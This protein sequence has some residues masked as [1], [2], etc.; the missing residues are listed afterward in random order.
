MTKPTKRFRGNLSLTCRA[1][2][3]VRE[4]GLRVFDAVISS[5]DP[6][7]MP[8]GTEIL[9]HGPDSVDLSAVT[10]GRCMVLDGHRG[11]PAGKVDKASIAGGQIVA[12]LLVMAGGR[13]GEIGDMWEKNISTNLSVGYT[14]LETRRDHVTENIYVTKWVLNEVSIVGVP[15]DKAA[16]ITR[17]DGSPAD[18]PDFDLINYR[19][20]RDADADAKPDAKPDTKSERD[21][22]DAKPDTKPEISPAQKL[23]PTPKKH[24]GRKMITEEEKTKLDVVKADIVSIVNNARESF[25]FDDENGRVVGEFREKII[26]DLA[27]GSKT[28]DAC[29]GETQAKM[30]EIAAKQTRTGI[31]TVD[32][33]PD[34]KKQTAA[35]R[36]SLGKVDWFEMQKKA[37]LDE[38][39]GMDHFIRAA[40]VQARPSFGGT[41]KI[42]GLINEFQEENKRQAGGSEDYTA[43]GFAIP[44]E[45]VALHHYNNAARAAAINGERI[46]SIS[47]SAGGKGGVT[48]QT[49]VQL[50][51]LVEFLYPSAKLNEYGCMMLTGLTNNIVIPRQ[52]AKATAAYYAENATISMS[53]Y[54]IGSL[55]FS[56]KRIGAQSGYSLQSL[57]NVGGNFM[58]S[59]TMSTLM[60]TLYSTRDDVFLNGDGANGKPKGI[61]NTSGI[62]MVSHGTNG[63]PPTLALT[64]RANLEIRKADVPG[65]PRKL[66]TPDIFEKRHV[67]QK[68]VGQ[69]DSRMIYDQGDP[70]IMDNPVWTNSLPGNLSKGTG[71]N[72]HA[73]ITSIPSE[74][75]CCE[76]G[77]IF[78]SIDAD[79]AG[80]AADGQ[81]VVTIQ[82]FN[83]I[84]VRRLDAFVVSKDIVVI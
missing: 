19:A 56:P 49:D 36:G 53:D 21:A 48:V 39:V 75:I 32:V 84:G 9:E 12:E 64:R 68:V 78:V 79:S 23:D 59:L 27:T 82:G 31:K 54:T 57:V 65:M 16:R 61:L 28:P 37:N 15:A 83:D 24:E 34:D 74:I 66:M 30:L 45:L 44:Q 42:T 13:S 29:R 41:D 4:D 33:K 51:L 47:G 11:G 52:T 38:S 10:D 71:T 22:A 1:K 46:Q 43:S 3:E 60:S 6:I 73:E 77:S 69:T 14:I 76:W 18:H 58:P 62:T 50:D 35:Q 20:K 25:N 17:E 72:L 63:G 40:V 80:T 26:Y 7:E 2:Q 8:W 67:T 70:M 81:V 5:N 55:S